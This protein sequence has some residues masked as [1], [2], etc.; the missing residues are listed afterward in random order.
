MARA[1]LYG[2][3]VSPGYAIGRVHL[4]HVAGMVEKRRIAPRQAEREQQRL[5]A[6]SEAVREALRE[7]MGK[8]PEDLAEYRE[9]IAAQMELARDPK[10]LESAAKRIESD[11][12][13]A[14]WA[15]DETINQLCALFDKM[16]DPYLRDR[17]QDIRAVGLRLRESLQGSRAAVAPGG[18]FWSF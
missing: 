17:A 5:R 3:A 12:I 7:A 15:L 8:V 18:A 10:L 4:L 11:L 13:C 16:E 6:A 1:L 9:V 14:S 2:T